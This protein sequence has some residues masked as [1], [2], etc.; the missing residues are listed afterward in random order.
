[1]KPIFFFSGAQWGCLS[2]PVLGLLWR[3]LDL[4]HLFLLSFRRWATELA[5]LVVFSRLPPTVLGT[6]RP[7]LSRP[8]KQHPE[9]AGLTPV[10]SVSLPFF[11]WVNKSMFL[12]SAS[13]GP[14]SLPL[15]HTLPAWFLRAKFAFPPTCKFRFVV[16]LFPVCWRHAPWMISSPAYQPCGLR[17]T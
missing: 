3:A 13:L 7:F 14:T 16:P 4:G 11:L 2:I 10:L 12:C 6:S 15:L 17:S 8:Q 1:M 9:L 5:S